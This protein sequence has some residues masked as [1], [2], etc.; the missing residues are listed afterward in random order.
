MS[1]VPEMVEKLKLYEQWLRDHCV[2]QQAMLNALCQNV[3]ASEGAIR[4]KYGSLEA[5][6]YVRQAF[7]GLLASTPEEFAKHWMQSEVAEETDE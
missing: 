7:L 2:Q 1:D 4:L 5:F 6:Q 3:K